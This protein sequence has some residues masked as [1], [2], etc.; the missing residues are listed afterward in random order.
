MEELT[1]QMAQQF[2]ASMRSCIDLI[3]FGGSSFEFAQILLENQIKNISHTGSPSQVRAC[4][5]LVEQLGSHLKELKT[6]E[7][8]AQ[9]MRLG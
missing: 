1:R 4:L 7:N 3:L 9:W 6:L 5:M 8:M 2:F